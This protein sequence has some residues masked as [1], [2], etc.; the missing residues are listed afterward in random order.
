MQREKPLIGYLV[1]WVLVPPLWFFWEYFTADNAWIQG[2]AHDDASLKKIKDYADFASK[3]W[4]G[5]LALLAGLV[6]L[7]S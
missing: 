2:I 6:A 7:K 1:F 4:A 5:V 3:V